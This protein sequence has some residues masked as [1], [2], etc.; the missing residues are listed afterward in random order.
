ME[1]SYQMSDLEH[2]AFERYCKSSETHK[3]GVV[4]IYK[5][6]PNG[7]L[8]IPSGE[9]AREDFDN[10][11]DEYTTEKY[12][13]FGGFE[14]NYIKNGKYYCFEKSKEVVVRGYDKNAKFE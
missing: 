5:V 2:D 12:D 7:D 3:K 4:R 9:M 11:L 6:E 8:F 1:K 13:E 14:P 10:Y